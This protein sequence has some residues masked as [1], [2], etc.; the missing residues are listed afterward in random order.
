[1]QRAIVFFLF[2]ILNFAA[3]AQKCVSDFKPKKQL[4]ANTYLCPN[5]M[6]SD[7][8]QL[9]KHILLTHPNPT[10]YTSNT[11]LI[12]AYNVAK[13]KCEAE[14]TVFDFIQIVNGY[15]S[16]LKDS[17]TGLN[18][19]DFLYQVNPGRKVLPFFITKIEGKFYVY[20]SYS[21]SLKIGEEVLA[22][23]QYTTEEWYQLAQKLSMCEGAAKEAQQEV[24]LDYIGVVYN[25]LNMSMHASKDAQFK[26]VKSTG[27]TV[28]QQVPYLATWKYYLKS[29]GKLSSDEVA[30]RFDENNNG[31]LSI[32]SFQPMALSLFEK[33]IDD[34]FLE[35]KERE[36]QQ[37]YIDLRD[38]L[39]GLL[40]AEEY[41]FSY[42]N[43]KSIPIQTNYLY[44]RSNYD[45]FALLSPFQ[46]KQFENRAKNVYPNGLISKE[47]D[48]Y[49]MPKGSLYTILYDYVPSNHANYTFK[50]K[51]DLIVN[52]NSMSAS[53]LFA[54]WF[55]HVQRGSILGSSCMGGMGGTFGN[56][57]ALSLKHSK[58]TVIVSTLKFTPLHIKEK[59][60]EPIVPDILLKP[61]LQDL[62]ERVDPFERY[63]LEQ[64]NLNK[65][66]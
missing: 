14:Q 24:A 23:D 37:I 32:S 56:P 62:K 6:L 66:K 25:L 47:Y 64:G 13:Q 5:S 35:V 63:L 39:G 21:D 58:I 45:R 43:E 59:V 9:H 60:L 20:G 54:G 55:K 4:A 8:E 38:N 30:Y 44:K 12:D 61:T 65:S 26:L 53:V 48:F 51:C 15:L 10:Y 1:M 57:A 2:V 7:L 52:G 27:D 40:R 33:K 16:T 36:C 17:H 42:I 49:R 34:F 18:P 22:I 3:Q 11:A 19:K 29:I 46:K 50:G 41:L 28:L 31:I